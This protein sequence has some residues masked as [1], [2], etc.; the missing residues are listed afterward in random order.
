MIE[1]I[2]W[3]YVEEYGI[4]VVCCLSGGGVVYYDFGNLNFS[5]IMFDDGDFFCDFVKVI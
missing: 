5:F 1:E 4:Y 3:D 2:N